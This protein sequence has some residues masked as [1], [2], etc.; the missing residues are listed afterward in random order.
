MPSPETLVAQL[1]HFVDPATGAV[2]PPIHPSTTYARGT[3]Y[4]LTAGKEYT[5][6]DNP[7]YVA[8]EELIATLEGGAAACLLASG[9]AAATTL[10]RAL[11]LPGK[12]LVVSR[13]MYHGFRTWLNE[14]CPRFGVELVAVDATDLAALEAAVLSG[15]TSLVWIETPANPTWDVVDIRGAATIAHAAGALL[16]VDSTAASPVHTR[17]IEHGADFVMHSATKY[18]NGHSDVLAG[19]IV[20]ARTGESF[21]LV[22]RSRYFEGNVLGP[23]EAWLL[24]RGM[25]TLFVRV[26]RA[27]ASAATL[28]GRLEAHRG[29]ERVL[30]PGL[31]SHPGHDIA[32]RQMRDG[33]GGMLSILVRGGPERALEVAGRVNVF[34][35][36]TSLGGVESLIEH[37]ATVEGKGSLAPAGLLR[38]SVGLEAV[39]DLWQDLDRALG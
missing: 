7:T 31:A 38:L 26:A 4:V 20:A 15:K 11:A 35:R 33:F 30:Y 16:A 36:A 27:S 32:K 2:V 1:R 34:L 28:A 37:R 3:D 19:A 24:L 39:E 12:R 29:V 22:L 10:V 5:R 18:L 23:F 17:P 25:R 14:Y 8:A 6:A 21:D 13:A 9:M